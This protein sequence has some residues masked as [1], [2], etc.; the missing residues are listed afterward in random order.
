MTR[1]PNR[2]F[3]PNVTS[4]A[5]LPASTPASMVAGSVVEPSHASGS[6]SR[7][8]EPCTAVE[9]LERTSDVPP[10][11]DVSPTTTAVRVASAV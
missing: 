4:S 1:A 7:A 2:F 8:K 3:R 9:P 5:P 11:N 6:A 10:L